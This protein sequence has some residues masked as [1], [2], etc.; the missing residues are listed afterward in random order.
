MR[1]LLLLLSALFFFP[2]LGN[3]LEDSCYGCCPQKKPRNRA[4]NIPADHIAYVDDEYMTGYIQALIDM[5]YYEFEVRVIVQNGVVFVFNLPNNE[6]IGNSIIC[7]IYDVPCI[8]EVRSV[9][10]SV[11]EFICYLKENDQELADC[12]TN[13][14]AYVSMISMPPPDCCR[15]KGIWLP[16]NT[17]LFQPLIAD[18]RQVTNSAALRFNDNVVGRHVGAPS[19]GNDFMFYRWLDV[20]K[21]RGDMDIGIQAGI[22]AVFDLDHPE[23]CMVNTDFFVAFM[24]T[25]AVNR[26]SWRFRLW[27]LSSHLGDEFLISNPGYDRRN[28]SDEGVDLFASYMI[29]KSIRVY[30]GIGDIF[31]RDSEFPEHPFY[32]EWGCE[33]RSFGCRD[34]YNRLYVQPVFAMHFRTWENNS[35]AVDQTY[36]LGVE[37]SKLQG[38]GQ[39]FRIMGEFHDGYSREGQFVGLRSN[40]IAIKCQY[41]Y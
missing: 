28:L 15:T 32:A 16:Q 25:Y 14:S 20:W 8:E 26:W 31:I 22:F 11:E 39:K 29:G 40:F 9:C 1:I 41:G 30:A 13:S 36:V 19:F 18:P 4:D 33:I 12:I 7:F 37:W 17:V 24:M 27:H 23:A 5:H 6:M 3:E 10:C 21:W 2:I 34:R 38:V 35:F